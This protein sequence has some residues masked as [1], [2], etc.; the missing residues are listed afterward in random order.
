MIEITFIEKGIE[1]TMMKIF[2]NIISNKTFITI[3]NKIC[4]KNHC[5]KLLLY[6]LFT[7]QCIIL[8]HIEAVFNSFSLLLF[9][10]KKEIENKIRNKILQGKREKVFYFK[11]LKKVSK[12][13]ITSISSSH[14]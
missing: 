14:C 4:K 2:K 7:L 13:S 3:N 9:K 6:L 8:L 11:L 5:L 1:I 12:N 10:K